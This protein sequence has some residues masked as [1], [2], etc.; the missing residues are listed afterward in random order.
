MPANERE[1]WRVM[2]RN[3]LVSEVQRIAVETTE[4]KGDDPLAAATLLSKNNF[5]NGCLDGDYDFKEA[6]NARH[7]AALCAGYVKNLCEKTIDSLNEY[8]GSEQDH[9]K[10]PFTA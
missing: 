8:D 3:N 2:V 1:I 7:F 6:E 5:E 9:W 4:S 10:N